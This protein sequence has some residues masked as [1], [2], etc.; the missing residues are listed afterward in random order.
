[1]YLC[2]VKFD[3]TQNLFNMQKPN[4]EQR[5]LNLLAT[6]A[7]EKTDQDTAIKALEYPETNLQELTTLLEDSMMGKFVD[8]NTKEPV[9][10]SNQSM[11]AIMRNIL[12]RGEELEHLVKSKQK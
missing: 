5:K 2:I 3:N 12:N 7:L 4:I 8:A 10:L 9:K 1:M 6:I 11:M